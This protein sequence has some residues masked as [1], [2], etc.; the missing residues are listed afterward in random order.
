MHTDTHAHTTHAHTHGTEQVSSPNPD[1]P[2]RLL[3]RAGRPDADGLRPPG[4]EAGRACGGP[5]APLGRGVTL[6]AFDEPASRGECRSG[7]GRRPRAQRAALRRLV[8]GDR[9]PRWKRTRVGR[10][11]RPPH[12]ALGPPTG[13][14][15]VVSTSWGRARSH[16]KVNAPLSVLPMSQGRVGCAVV[17][18][19]F[20]LGRP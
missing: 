6:V 12:A 9:M 15:P 20:L 7:A 4:Q 2:S 3:L 13:R 18:H 10:R 17:S 11:R 16:G 19:A 5:R 14:G 1:A 8:A